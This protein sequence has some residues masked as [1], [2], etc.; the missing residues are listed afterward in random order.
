[1]DNNNIPYNRIF[2]EYHGP[3][4]GIMAGF[5][6]LELINFINTCGS[7]WGKYIESNNYFFHSNLRHRD[8]DSDVDLSAYRDIFGI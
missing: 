2:T 3:I 1:M 7:K 4:C 8:I 6:K 5:T